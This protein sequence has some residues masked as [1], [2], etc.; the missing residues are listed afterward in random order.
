MAKLFEFTSNGKFF[1][2]VDDYNIKIHPKG[3]MNFLNKGG[4]KREKSIPIKDITAIQFSEPK[5]TPGY[6]QF[7]TNGA[8]E[9]QG[10]IT[11]VVMEDNTV[12]FTR[13]ELEKALEMIELIE[14]K[15]YA[16]THIQAPSIASKF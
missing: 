15:R 16:A 12:T 5:I 6:V 3:I 8:T 2:M 14:S 7:A 11:F 13:K 4:N 9:T 1:V 10:G